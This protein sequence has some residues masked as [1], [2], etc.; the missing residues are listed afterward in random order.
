MP[1]RKALSAAHKLRKP[2]FP[3]RL[4]RAAERGARLIAKDLLHYPDQ[5]D[6]EEMIGLALWLE[7]L[8]RWQL[9]RS[10]LD[11]QKREAKR[12]AAGRDRN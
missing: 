8:S 9:Q 10:E 6:A 1:L 12:N 3:P 7:S 4:A 11:R 5:V 2:T